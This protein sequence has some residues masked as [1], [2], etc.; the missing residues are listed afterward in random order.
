[1]PSDEQQMNLEL[2]LKQHPE[3]SE[4][5]YRF[6]IRYGLSQLRMPLTGIKGYLSLI[7]SGEIPKPD[8]KLLNGLLTETERV[9]VQVNK[10]T[11]FSKKY[12]NQK[13]GAEKHPHNKSKRIIMF[14]DD[15]F[16]MDMYKQKFKKAGFILIHF[17]H[18]P[19]NI[20]QIILDQ[21][22]DLICMSVIMPKCDGFTAAEKIKSDERT[23]DIPLVFL[24]TCGLREDIKK[25][26]SLGAVDYFV[27]SKYPP[28]KVIRKLTKIING[29][30][31]TGTMQDNNQYYDLPI[32]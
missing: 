4:E 3:I 11:D 32:S 26:L 8:K 25:G 31:S 20:V 5:D 22:P 7:V 15:N 30:R 19:D 29:E 9:M 27:K 28:S 23:K 1:M 24:T 2:W 17:E 21:K 14:E 18:P 6:W 12:E 10:L 13:R 16:L